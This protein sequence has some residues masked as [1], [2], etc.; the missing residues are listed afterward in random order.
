MY[1]T[2]YD[3]KYYFICIE[4]KDIFIAEIDQFYTTDEFVLHSKLYY[5]F[6]FCAIE[7][8]IP[9]L[10]MSEF[11]QERFNDL[12]RFKFPML[13]IIDVINNYPSKYIERTIAFI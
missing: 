11:Y 8:I 1:C 7:K 10:F 5:K 13:K 4:I 6:D 9:N 3:D 12:M 2:K